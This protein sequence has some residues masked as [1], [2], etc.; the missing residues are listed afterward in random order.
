[1]ALGTITVVKQAAAQ[2]P[3]FLDRISF[4]GDGSYPTGGT[5]AF[6][7]TFRTKIG[8]T[9]TIVAI[10]PDDCCVFRP[11]YDFAAKKLKVRNLTDGT[12][13]TNATS[14][15]STTFNLTVVSE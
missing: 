1:M 5:A 2:G 3:V 11:S 6:E 8:S 12:E 14:L 4:A 7:T 15:A 13:V 9:R 10:I